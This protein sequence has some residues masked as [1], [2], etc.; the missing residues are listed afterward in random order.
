MRI[1]LAAERLEVSFETGRRE[2]AEIGFGD[3]VY[4]LE[5]GESVKFELD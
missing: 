5:P 2:Q 1:D 3:Q 4:Q